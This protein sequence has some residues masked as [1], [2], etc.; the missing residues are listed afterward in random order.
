MKFAKI[1]GCQPKMSLELGILC[2]RKNIFTGSLDV[3]FNIMSADM[4]PPVALKAHRQW[5]GAP[6]LETWQGKA[7]S[8]GTNFQCLRSTKLPNLTRM[9]RQAGREFHLP[10][11]KRNGICMVVFATSGQFS[12]ISRKAQNRQNT[13]L[14]LL[15]KNILSE[16]TND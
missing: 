4:G 8:T 1:C 9:K 15:W 16:T 6:Q 12:D 13:I 11:K 7:V 2:Q 10:T 3:E 14:P 5:G